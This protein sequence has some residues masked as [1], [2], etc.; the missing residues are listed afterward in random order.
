VPSDLVVAE[1]ARCEICG[2]FCVAIYWT[3]KQVAGVNRHLL[4]SENDSYC[5]VATVT[6][7][8]KSIICTQLCE[9]TQNAFVDKVRIK[10]SVLF[11]YSKLT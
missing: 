10:K 1:P 9:F 2:H 8:F 4:N 5:L 7:T 3:K 11:L 6:K